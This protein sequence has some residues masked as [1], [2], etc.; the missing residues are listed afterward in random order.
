MARLIPKYW[1]IEVDYKQGSFIS[2]ILVSMDRVLHNYIY[3]VPFATQ[4]H[5]LSLQSYMFP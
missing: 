3:I 1:I 2:D 5:L 4:V